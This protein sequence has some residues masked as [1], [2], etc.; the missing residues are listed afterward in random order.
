MPTKNPPLKIIFIPE[1][2]AMSKIITNFASSKREDRGLLRVKTEIALWCNGST[3]VSGTFSEGSSPSK[4]T[5]NGSESVDSEP[6][7]LSLSPYPSYSRYTRPS[8][9]RLANFIMFLS[10][11]LNNQSFLITFA[12]KLSNET[13]SNDYRRYKRHRPSLR[14][15]IP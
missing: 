3:Q 4:A 13:H 10:R 2:L 12:K 8:H 6:F 11:F 9:E 7:I 1:N 15:Q 5:P 14:H